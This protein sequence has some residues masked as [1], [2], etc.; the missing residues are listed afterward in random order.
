[1]DK[2][3]TFTHLATAWGAL[4]GIG[5]FL[6]GYIV[7]KVQTMITKSEEKTQLK[8]DSNKNECDG[9]LKELDKAQDYKH[10]TIML[11]LEEIF[12]GMN[13]IDIQIVKLKERSHSQRNTDDES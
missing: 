12:K 5:V 7:L 4:A 6:F 1:M 8:I 13:K 2:G 10:E 11:K 3:I 9:K